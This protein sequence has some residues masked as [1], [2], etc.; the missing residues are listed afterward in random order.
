MFST[1]MIIP[2]IIVIVLIMFYMDYVV[3][4]LQFGGVAS[5]IEVE[6]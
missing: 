6:E 2:L 5:D 4:C 1:L 3:E